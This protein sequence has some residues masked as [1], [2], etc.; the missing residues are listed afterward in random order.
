M[1]Y[2]LLLQSATQ[3][4]SQLLQMKSRKS[5]PFYFEPLH[6]FSVALGWWLDSSS[7]LSLSRLGFQ[8]VLQLVFL[9]RNWRE[10]QQPW[11]YSLSW[12]AFSSASSVKYPLIRRHTVVQQLILLTIALSLSLSLSLFLRIEK[13]INPE[14]QTQISRDPKIRIRFGSRSL[15]KSDTTL[16]KRATRI[17]IRVTA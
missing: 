14:P 5:F 1:R 4:R 3:R 2:Q 7:E 6:F 13:G 8:L 12:E 15:S 9:P 10:T 11:S 16:N 17:Q